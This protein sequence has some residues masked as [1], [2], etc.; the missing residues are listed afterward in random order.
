MI[1]VE[2]VV[3]KE[4]LALVNLT[5]IED[6]YKI[7]YEIIENLAL[8]QDSYDGTIVVDQR[9]KI[10]EQNVSDEAKYIYA[11]ICLEYFTNEEEKG[12]LNKLFKESE[13]RMREEEQKKYD[14]FKDSKKIEGAIENTSSL[15]V[16]KES[17]L[18]K[19]INKIKE[20][21]NIK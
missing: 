15:A 18:E 17:L 12:V 3:A 4:V 1:V 13:E 6:A 5:S 7:P 14:P 9:K 21:L 2:P 11:T 10:E 16:K 19:I 8:I 20:I